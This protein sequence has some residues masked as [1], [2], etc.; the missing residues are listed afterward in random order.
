M[1]PRKKASREKPKSSKAT[2][3]KDKLARKV[4][5]FG[6]AE[7]K[8]AAQQRRQLTR[9]AALHP[10]PSRRLAHSQYRE[11]IQKHKEEKAK[12]AQQKADEE[13]ARIAEYWSR[14]TN[15]LPTEQRPRLPLKHPANF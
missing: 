1:A 15:K 6:A 12:S 10:R 7:R 2:L 5:E 8:L 13:R 14:R 11:A 9:L 3:T 4:W